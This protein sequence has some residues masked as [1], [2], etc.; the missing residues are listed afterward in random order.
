MLQYCLKV[1]RLR[2]MAAILTTWRKWIISMLNL[3]DVFVGLCARLIEEISFSKTL[4][5]STKIVTDKIGRTRIICKYLVDIWK[6]IFVANIPWFKRIFD[7]LSGNTFSPKFKF[8]TVFKCH[9]NR[10]K[11]NSLYQIL[12]P[13]N[14]SIVFYLIESILSSVESCY[15]TNYGFRNLL[16]YSWQKLLTGLKIFLIFFQGFPPVSIKICFERSASVS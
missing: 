3:H 13:K 6:C 11:L 4:F 5:A 7:V 14:R 15:D 10:A 8:I 1:R 2:F 9:E 16:S 12:S